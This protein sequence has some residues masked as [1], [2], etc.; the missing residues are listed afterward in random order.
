M[1]VWPGDP[2]TRLERVTSIA[3][4]DAFNVT[5]I[6]TCLHTGTHVDA[7]LHSIE[8]GGGI[9]SMP[10]DALTG[11]ARVI[12]I[13]DQ[14]AIR[15]SEL[16]PHRIRRGERILFKTGNAARVRRAEEAAEDF[17]SLSLEAAEHLAACRIRAAGI[18]GVSIGAADQEGDSVHR[19]L[20][21]AGIW[22]LEGLNLSA[23]RPGH[24]ELVCLPLRIPGAD[25]SPARAML[26]VR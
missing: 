22:I 6:S 4:G 11:P 24:Y 17:V 7:P 9:E 2:P 5:A 21:G 1:P 8:G 10:L 20:L 16:R 13:L 15:T 14:R 12:E 26:R 18:D 25:G 3:R 19:V 23:V